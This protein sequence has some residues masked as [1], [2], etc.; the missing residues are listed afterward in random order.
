LRVVRSIAVVLIAVFALYRATAVLAEA[1]LLQITRIE[2]RGNERLS[3][4]DVLA[5]LNGLRGENLMSADLDAWRDRLLRSPWVRDASLRRLL[6]ATVE[7]VVSERRP[8]GIGRM[9]GKLYLVDEQGS[10]IDEY[11]PVHADLDLPIIDGLA[12]PTGPAAPGENAHAQLAARLMDGLQTRPAVA[13]R[14][15]Q[16]DVRD[17]HNAAVILNGDPAV[18]YVGEDR[19]LPRLESYLELASTLRQRVLDIDY[20]D[21]RFDGRIYVRPVDAKRR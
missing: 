19:F 8:L 10:I 6:P 11:A 1:R 5:A 3:Q 20:V 12:A 4:G 16:I 17:P 9:A 18:I 13:R 7:V 2:V 21:L 15:S 14:I